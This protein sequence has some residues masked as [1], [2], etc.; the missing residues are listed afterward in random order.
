M[1]SRWRERLFC[2]VLTGA[3]GLAVL[4]STASIVKAGDDD[5]DDSNSIWNLDKRFLNS[6][7]K[8]IGFKQ[9]LDDRIEYRER[10]PLVIPPNRDLPPPEQATTESIPA[11]P[12][13]PDIMRRKEAAKRK[14]A[15]R[16]SYDPDEAA[17][18]LTPSE[19]NPPGTSGNPST[20]SNANGGD[21]NGP[22][23]TPSE[24]GYMGGLFSW[25]N[26]GF[27]GNKQE[28]GTFVSE[29]SRTTLTEPPVGYQTPSAAQPYGVTKHV[30]K[31]VKPLDPAVGS[32][33]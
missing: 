17:K 28:V 25:S 29:P 13:D 1:K 9:G 18:N 6:V 11:W 5:D 12:N 4:A 14:K 26:L 7:M 32:L 20:N 33:D 22:N 31:T 10:S 16:N 19:L 15:A 27:G 8:G 23:K 21:P 3:F 2:T 30:D 24:L